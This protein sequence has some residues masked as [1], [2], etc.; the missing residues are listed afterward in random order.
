MVVAKAV[1]MVS[2]A[3]DL[4]ESAKVASMAFGSGD[5]LVVQMVERTVEKKVVQ[6]V[7]TLATWQDE[8]LLADTWGKD[9]AD[10]MVPWWGL[11]QAEKMETLQAFRL[12]HILVEVKGEKQVGRTVFE[13]GTQLE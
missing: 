9:L 3:A 13:R 4:S 1:T 7:I 5:I 6:K 8:V 12:E 10:Q 11:G 2:G